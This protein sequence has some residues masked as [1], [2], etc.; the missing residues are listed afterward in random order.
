M[1][2]EATVPAGS[3]GEAADAV[4]GW[5]NRRQRAMVSHLHA[6]GQSL[7][8]LHLLG[9]LGETGPA[10]VSRL[11]AHLGITPPS[12]SAIVDRMVDAGLVVRERSEDDRRVV[13]V[14]LSAAGRATLDQA[15][16][17]RHEM[18]VRV[19]AELTDEE[20]AETLRVIDRLER[21]IAAVSTPK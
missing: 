14:S 13:T 17:S 10:T 15:T 8:Q 4:Q 11:A 2:S 21:A 7:S 1:T 6:C 16:G 20:R 19:L 3:V 12:A 18:L 9:L 5:I